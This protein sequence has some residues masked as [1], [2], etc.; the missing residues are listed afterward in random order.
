MQHADAP[1]ARLVA[2]HGYCNGLCLELL[3]VIIEPGADDWAGSVADMRKV[4]GGHTSFDLDRGEAQIAAV[5]KVAETLVALCIVLRREGI[6]RWRRN[7][8]Y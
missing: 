2:A 8:F 7:T 4:R 5:W 3:G 1:K 6:V